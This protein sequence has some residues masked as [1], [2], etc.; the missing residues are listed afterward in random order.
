MSHLP[1]AQRRKLLLSS[2]VIVG[3]TFLPSLSRA[4]N[5]TI[6]IGFPVPLTGSW[7]AEANDQVRAA[8]LAI[9]QFNEAGGLDGRRAEL[10]VRDDRLD[11]KEAGKQTLE[12]IENDKVHFIVGSLSSETQILTNKICIENKILFNSISQSD[13]INELANAS[14]YTFHEA[15]NPH[16][17]ASAVA[18]YAF[19]KFGKR[20]A[21]ITAWYAF[22]V[23]MTRG[24][25]RVG[26]KL[27][28]TTVADFRPPKGTTDFTPWLDKIKNLKPDVVV[29]SFLGFEGDLLAKQVTDMG[30]KAQSKCV[31]PILRYTSRQ[32]KGPEI[33]DQIVGGTSYCWAIEDRIPSAKV[34]N[35]LFKTAYGTYPSDYGALG[36]AG[37]RSVLQSVKD[38]Q[39]TDSNKVSAAMA[40][41]KYDWYKGPQH[42]RSCDHQSVQSVIIVESKSR[43][44]RNKFDVFNILQIE[45]ST[46]AQLRTCSELGFKN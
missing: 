31:M 26:Q 33:Y 40:E 27:G 18:R 32:A 22:G 7:T 15:L 37:V 21:Y 44:M 28:T 38:A 13:A 43:N 4:Q 41:L 3:T 6:K 2:A 25:Q 19:N 17:T 36:Y 16:M 45:T 5:Q 8:K 14:P 9:N 42:Y 35:D 23:D 29:I 11:V 12:L 34:F 30:I 24:F 10:L 46:E 39:S 1:I 20:I